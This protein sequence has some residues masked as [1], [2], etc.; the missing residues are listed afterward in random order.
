[1]SLIP[2][3]MWTTKRPGLLTAEDGYWQTPRSTTDTTSVEFVVIGFRVRKL[4][5]TI[6]NQEMQETRFQMIIFNQ[7][8]GLVILRKAAKDGNQ[9]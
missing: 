5:L 9:K 2:K 8:I 7:Y 1:M 3:I 4:R 6:S